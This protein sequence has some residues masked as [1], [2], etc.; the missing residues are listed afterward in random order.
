V[1]MP[2]HP[3]DNLPLQLSS[4]VGRERESSEVTRLL[5]ETRLLTG[6]GG[7]GKTRLALRVASDLVE[8]FED[9]VWVVELASLA[10]PDLVPQTVASTLGVNEQPGRSLSETLS[11][12]L[13]PKRLLLILDNCE[14]LIDACAALVNALLRACP[15]L[16]IL[17][18]SREPLGVS[19]EI[20]W[21][22]PSLSSPD[23]CHLPPVEELSSYEAVRLFVERVTA[24]LSNFALTE[25]NASAVVEVCRKLDGMPLAIELAAARVRLLSV[26][27]ISERLEECFRLLRTNSHTAVA[28]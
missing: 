20:S 1:D 22:V 4:F 25:Q 5:A 14:H 19:G 16:R 11:E 13:E 2:E 8:D 15:N 26:G 12:Y 28:R 10:D 3:P 6:P 17:V 24:V 18:T 7:C 23:P 27:Q 21:V 9:G